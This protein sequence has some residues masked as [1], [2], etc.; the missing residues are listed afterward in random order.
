MAKI[1]REDIPS[2]LLDRKYTK[3]IIF[4]SAGKPGLSSPDTMQGKAQKA[5]IQ[6][7]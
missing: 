1:S 6:E 7:M 2:L 5:V 3:N 4:K